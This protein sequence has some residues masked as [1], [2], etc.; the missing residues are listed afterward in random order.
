MRS[1]TGDLCIGL[2]GFGAVGRSYA[3]ALLQAGVRLQVYNPAPRP[4]TVAAATEMGIALHGELDAS[5]NACDLLLNAA[6]GSQALPLAKAAAPFLKPGALF[7]DLSSA[8]PDDVRAAAAC[9][10]AGAYVDVAILGAVSIHGHATPMLASGAGAT[11]LQAML[12]PLGLVIDTLPDGRPGDATTLKL[13]RSILTKGLDALVIECLLVAESLGLRNALLTSLA[14]FDKSTFSELMAMY[15][16]THGPNA[17]R[18]QVEMQ[19]VEAMLKDVDVPLMMT[20]ATTRRYAHSVDVF[21]GAQP[22]AGAALDQVDA[23]TISWMLAA[24]R[25]SR[26]KAGTEPRD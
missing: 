15:V 1:A 13:L 18:R 2:I 26:K 21:S 3:S 6:P 5:V 17:A 9:F 14:D 24:E 7:A 12:N 20:S 8:A 4:E 16:R 25:Q 11:T 19:A 22:P 23:E 10:P